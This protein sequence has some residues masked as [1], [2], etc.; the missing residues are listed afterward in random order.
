MNKEIVRA[1]TLAV[2]HKKARPIFLGEVSEALGTSLESVQTIMDDLTK[3]GEII[4]LTVE[5]LETLLLPKISCVYRLT[6][7]VNPNLAY[8]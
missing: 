8:F 4:L 6:G 7:N 3:Q 2:F 1:R 5:E